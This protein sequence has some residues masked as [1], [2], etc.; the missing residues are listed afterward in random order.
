LNEKSQ[1]GVQK[2]MIRIIMKTPRFALTL[3][4]V[5]AVIASSGCAT[6]ATVK[7]ESRQSVRFASTEAAQTFYEAYLARYYPPG[8]GSF[9]VAIYAP[10]PYHHRKITTDNV[11]FNEAVRTTDKNS[12]GM[13]SED[14][15]SAYAA[16]VHQR[17]AS[18]K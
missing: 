5:F 15:A 9:T 8:A 18:R 12:D 17:S 6:R 7:D 4:F 3:V 1:Q 2:I 13:I 14:E 11:F 16:T 10:L